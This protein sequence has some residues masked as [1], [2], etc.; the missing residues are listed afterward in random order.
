[1]EASFEIKP[2][3]GA[4]NHLM[5]AAT[6]ITTG[7]TRVFGYSNQDLT[8]EPPDEFWEIFVLLFIKHLAKQNN[9]T[10]AQ[11]RTYLVGK[12]FKF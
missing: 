1:M 9:F 5:I 11:L 10:K 4:C 6:N 7:N 3:T 12:T 8:E 2:Q